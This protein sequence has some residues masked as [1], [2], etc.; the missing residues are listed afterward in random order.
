MDNA[1]LLTKIKERFPEAQEVPL[2]DPKWIRNEE[3]QVSVSAPR[4][5]E[6]A[7]FLKN[8]LGYDFLNFITAVDWTKTN[9]F[10]MVYHFL[11]SGS[12]AEKIFLKADL[13]REAE[14]KVP[15][16]TSLWAA[17]DWQEREIYDMFGIK[18]EGH[19]DLRR[20]LLWEGYNGFPLRKDYVH[21]VDK[22]DNGQEIGVP[23]P[24]VEAHKAATP[25]A[26]S[27]SNPALTAPPIAPAKA[28]TAPAVPSQESP[29]PTP[30]VVNPP[31]PEPPKNEGGKK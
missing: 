13:P 14:P 1:A 21:T 19:F 7:A 25:G 12:P 11:K 5:A 26:P 2:T 30:P 9:K 31:A 6:V 4:L 29:K 23:K 3:L 20:I 10:E 27:P 28:S 16:L 17:A 8:D 24:A 18:F 22:Y 15:S